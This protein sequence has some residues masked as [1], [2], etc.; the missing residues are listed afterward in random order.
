LQIHVAKADLLDLTVDA[1]V[2]PANSFAIMGAGVAGAAKE[3]GGDVIEREARESAP[4]AV[5]A[6][7]I[8][9]GGELFAKH[10]IHAPT[11]EEPGMRIGVENVRRATR[12]AL[13]AANSGGFSLI[14]FPAMGTGVGGVP[15]EEATRAMVDEIRAHKLPNP[16]TIY[17][18]G[19]SELVLYCFE[20]A[21]RN[22]QL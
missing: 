7:V 13:I 12:A 17:L 5:G 8:T 14:A 1:I 10:V 16:Q 20:D 3:R 19:L 21:L 18:I 22:S 4:I 15:V 11:M 9:G 2:V 6:A